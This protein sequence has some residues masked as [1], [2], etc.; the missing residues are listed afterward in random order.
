[1][2]LWALL[3]LL[4]CLMFATALN[5]NKTDPNGRAVDATDDPAKH[6]AFQPIGNPPLAAVKNVS[7][8]M[9]GIDHFILGKLE[10]HELTRSPSADKRT[11]IR[12]AT[13]DLIGLP[14]TPDEIA[15]FEADAS[16]AAFANVVDRLLAS[17]HYGERW[18]RHWLDVARYADTKGYVFFEEATYPWAFTYRDYVLQAFND[19]LPYDQFILEQLAADL[20]LAEESRRP[21]ASLRA[22]GVPPAPPRR[23]EDSPPG[24]GANSSAHANRRSLRALGFLT[25]GSRFMSNQFDILDDRI[26]VVTRGLM[27]LTVSCARCHD[28]KFDPIPTK[29]YYS[30]YGV[31]AGSA[32]PPVPPL[33][34][35]PPDTEAYRKFEQELHERER[36]LTAFVRQKHFEVVAGAR[37]RAGEYLAAAHASRDQPRTDDFMLLADGSDL[38]PKM[39]LRWQVFLQ[40]TRKPHHPVLSA[41]HAFAALEDDPASFAERARE[42]ANKLS[43]PPINPLVALAFVGLPPANMTEVA[44]RYGELLREAENRWQVLLAEAWIRCGGLLLPEFTPQRLDNPALEELRQVLYGPETPPDLAMNPLGDLE[45]LP[46]R[47]AQAELQKLRGALEQWR[48]QGPGAPPRAMVLEDSPSQYAQRVFR[49]GNP[50]NQGEVVPRRFLSV[51]AGDN[52]KPFA[53]GSGRLE[54]ARAIVNRNNPL[55]ARVIV[56]RVWLHH[57]GQGLVRTPSDFGLRSQPPTHPELLDHLA[58]WFMDNGWSLKKLHRHIM[59]S[60]TYQQV[61]TP[62]RAAGFIP[63]EQFDPENTLLWRMNR[64][65]LDF[66]ST[67]DA[68]LAVSGRLDRTIGGPSVK[69]SLAASANRRSLYSHLDRLNV[70]GLL[71]T[72]DFPNPD[73]TSPQRDQTT[74]PPQALFLMNHPFVI[75]CARAL[76]KRPEIAKERTMTR[77]V[78][79]LHRL[80]YGREPKLE[81]LALAEEYLQDAGNNAGAWERYIQVLLMANEF[82]FVD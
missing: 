39:I 77:R 63:A 68:L 64:R 56:N 50:N 2:R 38:N 10:Q 7:W 13:F 78:V 52:P 23:L 82:V 25:L 26:D 80:L 55:T 79:E 22:S 15:A 60:A 9:T 43:T 4:V 37:K 70:P 44:Q 1:M 29:D 12:R 41:W 3:V 42:V 67:R 47:P 54:L 14:P 31:F 20:L 8:P 62:K 65:R 81:G 49:R 74:V 59:L 6:W 76:L 45:L 72:F 57:F 69:D 33:Y 51:L 66:E 16:P 48:A 35:D 5:A 24:V 53:Q 11:L 36:R 30:L 27:G 18:G 61:S 34:E 40:R 32:E 17:P 71:R 58:A 19:D 28:H 75:D 21:D 46:D 73:A